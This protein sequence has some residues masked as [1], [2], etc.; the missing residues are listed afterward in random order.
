[1]GAGKSSVGRGLQARTGLARF[2]LDEIVS[3]RLQLSI[4]EIFSRRGEEGFRD[5]ETAALRELCLD[6]PAIVVTGGGVV[7]RE[8][9]IT[10]LK[11]LGTIVWLDGKEE[12]LFERATRKSDRPL[13]QTNEPRVTFS[14]LLRTR[15]PLY[16]K[17]AQVRI[18]TSELT[19]EQVVDEILERIDTLPLSKK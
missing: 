12:I 3:T 1:M 18:D 6:R 8:E 19:H 14:E 15:A 11:R 9:N 16:S 7:L 13:L 4:A 17:A 10:I 5:A 2:D